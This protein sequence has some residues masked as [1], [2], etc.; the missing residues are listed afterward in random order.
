LSPRIKSEKETNLRERGRNR[1]RT[2]MNTPRSKNKGT[3]IKTLINL[4]KKP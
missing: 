2:K 3:G 4:R 1:K